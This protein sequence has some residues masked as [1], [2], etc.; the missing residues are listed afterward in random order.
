MLHEWWDFLTILTQL[1]PS[2]L[3]KERCSAQCPIW[4][5]GDIFRGRLTFAIQ[6][7]WELQIA[8]GNEQQFWQRFP[9]GTMSHSTYSDLWKAQNWSGLEHGRGHGPS[10]CVRLS[11]V[12]IPCFLGT[13]RSKSPPEA[14]T[15]P[16]PGYT[17]AHATCN[18]VIALHPLAT[19][20]FRG[21][22]IAQK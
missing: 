16:I 22:M 21:G 4:Q 15:P 14:L 18:F 10:L 20:K 17:P 9:K 1:T 6:L 12:V 7:N 3:V 8:G 11:R 2:S 19:I 5:K 13:F